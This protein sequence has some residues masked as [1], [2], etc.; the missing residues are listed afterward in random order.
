M[1]PGWIII[2]IAIGIGAYCV[3]VK[4]TIQQRSY[5]RTH[6]KEL[7]EPF[8]AEVLYQGEAVADLSDREFTEMF[9]RDY[10]IE[11]R[12]AQAKKIIE[13]DDLWDE[14]VFDFRDPA[15]GSICTSGVVGGS[16]PFIRGG[17]ISLR[18]LYFGGSAI[19]T[20]PEQAD[21]LN[22]GSGRLLG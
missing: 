12:S 15:S 21:A 20:K 9:W 19:T 16:R 3:F 11:P 22:P 14:C 17:R 10:R 1:P 6:G 7:D 18:A 2:A 13:N 5:E 4:P 8:M